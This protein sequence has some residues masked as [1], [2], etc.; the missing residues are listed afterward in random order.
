MKQLR[1][2]SAVTVVGSA[3]LSN[4]DNGLLVRLENVLGGGS[5]L[6]RSARAADEIPCPGFPKLVR[7]RDLAAN[8]RGLDDFGGLS[9]DALGTHGAL[10]NEPVRLT[11]GTEA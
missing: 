7:R 2:R 3:L 6:F 9:Y 10:L 4:E 1:G 8:V 11:A 5:A